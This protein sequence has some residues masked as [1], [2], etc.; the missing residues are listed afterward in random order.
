MD[1]PILS[2]VTDE[3]EFKPVASNHGEVN[4]LAEE[5]TI[6]EIKLTPGEEFCYTAWGVHYRFKGGSW[7]ISSIALRKKVDAEDWAR[8]QCLKPENVGMEAEVIPVKHCLLLKE[9]GAIKT[10]T[11]ELT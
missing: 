7:Q 5:L 8:K 10:S 9:S 2:M 3:G 11:E 4:E 6:G 1:E